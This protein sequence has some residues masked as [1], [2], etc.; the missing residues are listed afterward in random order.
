MVTRKLRNFRWRKDEKD[1]DIKKLAD[2]YKKYVDGILE[3][4]KGFCAV[5]DTK[6]IAEQDYILTPVATWA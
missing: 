5:K 1:N 4:V 2:T 3:D 6:D